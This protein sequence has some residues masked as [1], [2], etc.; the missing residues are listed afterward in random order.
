[1]IRDDKGKMQIVPKVTKTGL[2]GWV[3]ICEKALPFELTA[4]FLLTNDA[5]GMPKPIKLQ[6]QHRAMFPLDKPI[7]EESGRKITAWASGTGSALSESEVGALVGTLD[8]K[9]LPEL[10]TA[11]GAAWKRAKGDE[12]ARAKLKS[13]YDAMKAAITNGQI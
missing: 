8:V 1:M 6:E 10:E 3:P 5:P 7:N 11:F 13:N 9:T 4:S 12:T 2:D